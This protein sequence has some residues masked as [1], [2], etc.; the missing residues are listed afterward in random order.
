MPEV[1]TMNHKMFLIALTV[2]SLMLLPL[3]VGAKGSEDGRSEDLEIFGLELEKVLNLGSGI[4]A[5]FLGYLTYIAYTRTN[6]KR[7][8]YV[9]L[10]FAIF[11]IKGFLTSAELF[12]NEGPWIDPTA[13]VLDFVIL[14]VFFFGIIKK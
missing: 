1:T 7:L 3:S 8:K 9:S 13:S 4:L 12:F 5:A 2:F 14:L 10:A 11:A 6:N